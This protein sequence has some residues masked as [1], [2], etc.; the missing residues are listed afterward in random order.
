MDVEELPNEA[1][2][3]SYLSHVSGRNGLECSQW[4][5]VSLIFISFE[6]G[7]HVTA[8]AVTMCGIHMSGCSFLIA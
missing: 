5:I 6:N 3:L 1:R 2:S 7:Q 8:F 4:C